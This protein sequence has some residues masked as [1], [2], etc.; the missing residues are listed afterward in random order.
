ME[1]EQLGQSNLQVCRVGLGTWAMGG[2]MWGGADEKEAVAAIRYA[3]DIG[4]NL[5]DTAPVYGF[6]ISETIVGRA[7]KESGRREH[8]ILATKAGLEW[9]GEERIW[10][11][12]SSKRLEKE[13][14]D[15]LRR[16][17]TDYIDLYQIHWPDPETPID[18]TAETLNRF[19]EEGKIRA[20]GV[21]NFDADQ[22]ETWLKAA[23]LHSNQPCLNLFQDALKDTVFPYCDQNQIGTLTWGTLAHGLLTGKFDESSS[24]PPDDLRHHHPMFQKKRFQQYLTAVSKLKDMAREKGKT[25]LQLS[26]RWVLDQPGVTS[27]LWGA[28][29]PEQLKE[30]K[31][32]FG[33]KLSA[34]DLKQIDSIVRTA[35]TDPLLQESLQGPPAKSTVKR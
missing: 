15:S 10:R 20:I 12:A 2:W 8:T 22:M 16:L 11:N 25:V 29:R 27:A 31:G 3:L 21:S 24:F 33:W 7:V 4:I 6:G 9:D 23:P 1:K 34:A 28:R 35:V 30:L 32:V 17:Q 18:E 5:V 19:Y 13:L 14:E 26:I